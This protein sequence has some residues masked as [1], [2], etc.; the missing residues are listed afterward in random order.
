MATLILNRE[1]LNSQ[2]ATVDSSKKPLLATKA[3]LERFA[4][5]LFKVAKK[6]LNK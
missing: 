6:L 3:E 4:P 5:V 1:T 2:L